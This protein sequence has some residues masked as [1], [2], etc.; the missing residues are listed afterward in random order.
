MYAITLIPISLRSGR[1]NLNRYNGNTPC[2]FL[3][4]AFSP[5]EP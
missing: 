1:G 3:L 4:Q 5:G 2:T